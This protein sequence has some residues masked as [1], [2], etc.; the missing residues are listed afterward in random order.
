MSNAG[1]KYKP[2]QSDAISA[3]SS[4]YSSRIRP[5]TPRADVLPRPSLVRRF[6]AAV[7]E[8]PVT[9][10]SAAA[11]YGKTTLLAGLGRLYE[12]G[13]FAWLSVDPD[14]NS[15]SRFLT[16]LTSAIAKAGGSPPPRA[17]QLLKQPVA[18]TSVL[19]R[20]VSALESDI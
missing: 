6:D 7:R 16:A 3:W 18:A 1:T 14:D 11:G 15:P 10:V 17:N 2:D 9:L 12:A 5:P 8:H 13:S 20:I 19:R 4:F